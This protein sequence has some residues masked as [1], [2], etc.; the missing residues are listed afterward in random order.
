MK[1]TKEMINR[2]ENEHYRKEDRAS[3][4]KL[5]ALKAKYYAQKGD[6]KTALAYITSKD[7]GKMV[8][9]LEKPKISMVKK[10]K[11]KAPT[12]RFGINFDRPKIR[13]FG[14]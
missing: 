4:V 14:L 10:K 11:K 13:G 8:R 9:Q 7:V 6:A 2:A 5:H 12:N 3:L 1:V